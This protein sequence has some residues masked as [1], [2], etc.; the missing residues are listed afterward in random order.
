MVNG[1]EAFLE[2]L[3]KWE[4][5]IGGRL[6]SE[7]PRIILRIVEL[8]STEE[9]ISQH[10]LQEGLKIN[11]SRLSKLTKKLAVCKWVVV[12]KSSSDQR[13]LLIRATDLAKAK[14]E[15]LQMEMSAV[16]VEPTRGAPRSRKTLKLP[17]NMIPLE[18]E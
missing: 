4:R 14:V 10:A 17:P 13:V 7:D 2:M 8:T 16:V 5:I 12:R 6:A 18:F 3:S 15:M 9:G 1:T 11:Q